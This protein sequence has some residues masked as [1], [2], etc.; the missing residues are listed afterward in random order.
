[1]RMVRYAV[2]LHILFLF[3]SCSTDEKETGPAL[4]QTITLNGK[5]QRDTVFLQYDIPEKTIRAQRSGKLERLVEGP[6]FKKNNLLVQFDDYDAFVEL[7]GEKEALKE[8]LVN[9]IDNIP[10][11]LQPIEKKWR[12]FSN[13]LT[14]DKMVPPLPAFEYKEEA[15]FLEDVRIAENYNAL[16]K[17]ELAIQ[18]YFQLSTEDG[19]ITRAHAHT[20]QYV[21][22]NQALLSYHP[23]RIQVTAEAAF[24]LSKPIRKQITTDLLVRMPVENPKPVHTEASKVIYQL[25]ATQKLDPRICPKYVIINHDQHVFRVPEE[26]VGKDKKVIILTNN[27]TVKQAVYARNGMYLVYSREKSIRIKRP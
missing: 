15:E 26:F 10:A 13:K 8:D 20:D 19:F 11:N 27:G 2:C 23:K 12:D 3:L 21:K 1:M 16:H 17:K 5:Q 14:P 7:S 6:V 4:P 25:T 24:P 22:K 9:H 18:T